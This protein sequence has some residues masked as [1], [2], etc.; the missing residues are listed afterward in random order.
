MDSCKA[1]QNYSHSDM[2]DDKFEY[3]IEHP[4][5]VRLDG[6]PAHIELDRGRE[7][8]ACDLRIA[9]DAVVY[10]EYNHKL[11]KSIMK[12]TFPPGHTMGLTKLILEYITRPP[13]GRNYFQE[14]LAGDADYD[15]NLLGL[16]KLDMRISHR[17][18]L[19]YDDGREFHGIGDAIHRAMEKILQDERR[20]LGYI[21]VDTY[22]TWQQATPVIDPRTAPTILPL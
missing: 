20:A 4:E 18:P 14:Y 10:F 9:M 16:R 5:V 12:S 22:G 1:R 2:L 3:W 15:L 11:V 8:W 19:A 17:L 6:I 7:Q 21:D 13:A